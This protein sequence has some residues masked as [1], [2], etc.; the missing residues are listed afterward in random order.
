MVARRRPI[1]A[2]QALRNVDGKMAL[3]C[4]TL[5]TQRKD[6]VGLRAACKASITS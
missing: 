1:S 5:D 6:S 4:Q 2:A 3:L